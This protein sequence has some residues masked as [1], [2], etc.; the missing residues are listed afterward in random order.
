MR[1]VRT[2]RYNGVDQVKWHINNWIYTPVD[3][4]VTVSRYMTLSPGD[5]LTLGAEGMSPFMQHG[6]IVEAEITGIGTL[7][8]RFVRDGV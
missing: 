6:D 1:T 4:L 5:I 3:V 7:R 2:V 8:N